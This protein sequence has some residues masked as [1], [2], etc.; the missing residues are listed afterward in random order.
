ME[1]FYY[2]LSAAFERLIDFWTL[3]EKQKISKNAIV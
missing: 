3:L 2:S 1:Q